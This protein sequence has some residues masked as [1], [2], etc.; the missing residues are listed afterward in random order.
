MIDRVEVQQGRYFDSV[1]LMLASAAA[2]AAPGVERALVAMATD[3]NRSLLEGL[4]FA[5]PEGIGPDDLIVAVRASDEP[6]AATAVAA[7]E[8][9]LAAAPDATGGL[10]EPPPPRR[11]GSTTGATLALISV[12]GVHAF[13]EAMDALRAGMSVMV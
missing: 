12:P 7:A 10:F 9:A 4:G 1:R 8:A 5:A 6:S 11:V 3:L 2:E 13:V